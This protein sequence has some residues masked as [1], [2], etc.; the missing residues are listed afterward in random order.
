MFSWKMLGGAANAGA[1]T[2][3]CSNWSEIFLCFG[4][5]Q[6]TEFGSAY[7]ESGCSRSGEDNED[8][9]SCCFSC[10]ESIWDSGKGKT[11]WGCPEGE[12]DQW[13]AKAEKWRTWIYR[14][15]LW[16]RGIKGRPKLCTGL[17]HGGSEDG[18]LY[19]VQ[20]PDLWHLPEVCCTGR[21]TCLFN[22]WGFYGCYRL[23]AY[24]P[25]DTGRTCRKD[26]AGNLW[27]DRDYGDSWNWYES[28]SGE[29]CDGYHGKA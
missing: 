25:A 5:V 22:R 11:F 3:L 14:A 28:V 12:G 16:H 8:D 23:S 21:H 26:N 18:T 9:L 2:Q 27:A 17:Y 4:G 10:A 24:L 1:D 20:H 13:R 19:E 29:D 6:G 7:D 15:I